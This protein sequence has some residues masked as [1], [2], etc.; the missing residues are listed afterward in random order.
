M[1]LV[2]TKDT[3][4]ESIEHEVFQDDSQSR[5]EA[6]ESKSVRPQ[7]Q[8]A[9]AQRKKAR[10]L[11]KQQQAAE[12]ISSSSTQLA[13]GI[14]QAFAAVEELNA[15]ME[16]IG[17]SAKQ[18]ASASHQSLG[19]VSQ[20]LEKIKSQANDAETTRE[21]T[22]AL[23][24]LLDKAGNEIEELVNNVG[25]ASE[26][27]QLSIEKMSELE[28]Q[29]A[30]ISESV[31]AVIRIADQ[32]NLLALN[33]AIE[34]A[35]AG[36]HGKG[37][38]VVAD[39]VRTLAETAEK[40]AG[41][42]EDFI[43]KIQNSARN[44]AE[45][46][47][48]TS[49]T[50]T[51]EAQ[52]GKTVTDQLNQIK[53]DMAE[54]YEGAEWIV[55]GANEMEQAAVQTQKASE[56]IASTSEEQSSACEES[57]RALRQQTEALSGSEKAAREL[58]ELAEE[59][60][61]STDIAKSAEEVA[62]SAE[63]LSASM[64]E[65]SRSSNEILT[66]IN[67]IN[68]GAVQQASAVEQ[69]VAGVGQIEKNSKSS[70]ER[71]VKALELGQSLGELVANNKN[72]VDEMFQKITD[73]ME[74]GRKN[75]DEI[76]ELGVVSRQIDKIVDAIGNVSIQTSMLAV[77]GAVEAARAG[78]YGKGFAVV[79]TDIQN[80]ANDAAQNAEQIKDL[81]KGIQEQLFVVETDLKDISDAT[82]Q[83]VSNAKKTTEK[84]MTI[85]E[86]IRQVLNWNT[87]MKDASGFIVTQV[88]EV[89]VGL[90]Q[91]A[92]GAEQSKKATSQASTAAK[93]QSQ[94]TDELASAIEEIASIADDL[95]SGS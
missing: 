9:N 80:L 92:T 44:I 74:M 72:S 90:E 60:K 28:K 89:R 32:T 24:L 65:I 61:T 85:E 50:V 31:K 42:I 70:E 77:N 59:L 30:N 41:N 38:A 63:E 49:D 56:D 18:S 84:L 75:Q 16:Q 62:A 79:S 55:N 12:R 29:A 76:Q 37:F 73:A 48:Q 71:A 3:N 58:D 43:T 8:D 15:S 1:A 13:S 83:E 21:K 94:G 67:Q 66:A 36:K 22:K 34:A 39:A 6:Y 17:S 25:S 5:L 47:Q 46:V 19:N 64:E 26:R 95:Q 11:A 87:S 68:K 52:K 93:Q 2:K 23:Q 88:S 51:T 20:C 10:T 81:V 86:D 53:D 7:Q 78:E 4:G 40:N 82:I 57:L 91:I 35:R 54:V 69:A 27:Q 14:S 33:A 45:G